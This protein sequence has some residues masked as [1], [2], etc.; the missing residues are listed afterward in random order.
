MVGGL[1]IAQREA[2]RAA[3]VPFADRIERVMLYGSR[4]RGDHRAGSDI[5]LLLIGDLDAAGLLAIAGAI[6][7]SDLSVHADVTLPPPP[8]SPLASVIER[9][10]VMLFD[11]ATLRA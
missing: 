8:E 9:E 5:D 4:A 10:A 3:L 2:L 1:T 11:G 7:A 6:E